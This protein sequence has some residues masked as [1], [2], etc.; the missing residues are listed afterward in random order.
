MKNYIKLVRFEVDRFSKI[1]GALIG[2]TILLQ[3]AAV[4]SAG[5]GYMK[6]ANSLILEQRYTSVQVIE[7]LGKIS[8]HTVSYTTLFVS[9]IGIAAVSLLIY[10]L[11]IWYR[12]WFGKNMFIYRLLML[13]LNRIQLFFAKLTT[14]LL[15]VFGLVAV[16]LLL[17]PLE[18]FL[19]RK[20]TSAPYFEL[21]SLETLSQSHPFFSLILPRS[22]SGFLIAYGIGTLAVIVLFTVILFE[23]SYRWKGIFIGAAYV[24]IIAAILIGPL[25]APLNFL[26]YQEI[27]WLYLFLS[28]LIGGVSIWLSYW[29]LQHKVT[30]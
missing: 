8:M 28:F 5:M 10:S 1:Y 15:F 24:L 2:L 4:V 22:F 11:F 23:R 13:P 25:Y 19:L 29:L 7:Q 26:F 21:V 18:D 14:I 9:S 6:E 12:D 16:Q 30:V 20:I 3:I 17:F 27:F